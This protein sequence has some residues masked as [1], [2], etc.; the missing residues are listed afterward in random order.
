MYIMKTCKILVQR[1]QQ[2]SLY[3]SI[4]NISSISSKFPCQIQSTPNLVCKNLQKRFIFTE[5]FLGVNIARLKQ[6]QVKKEIAE[7]KVNPDELQ[8]Q[9]L[10]L[11][12]NHLSH[13]SPQ[14]G[15]SCFYFHFSL[16]IQFVKRF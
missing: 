5:E 3:S 8:K 9:I 14:S 10:N 11:I 2:C 4:T 1:A 16:H 6:E 13:I 7:E 12:P 15:I